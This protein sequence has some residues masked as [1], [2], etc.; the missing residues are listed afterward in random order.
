M[1]TVSKDEV[2]T[3]AIRKRLAL[4]G[5]QIREA[6]AGIAGHNWASIC[7]SGVVTAYV[8]MPGE[9]PTGELRRALA[10]HGTRVAL[11]IMRPERQLDWG[12]DETELESNSYGILEPKPDSEIEISQV[13]ALFIPAMQV[14]V[15]G[16]RLGR[17][18]GYFD[19]ALENVPLYRD[20]G[21]QRIVVAFDHEVVESVPHQ[22]HDAIVDMVV[23][24][25][26][27][28]TVTY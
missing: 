4:T 3:E 6:S 25:T 21:P 2:R 22:L 14:G 5:Q 11:P 28:I 8:S 23:T 1:E 7:G 26:R 16:S 27:I 20:G 19:R 17:G 24:P 18:A 13:N 12:W 10:A 15:D 9:P